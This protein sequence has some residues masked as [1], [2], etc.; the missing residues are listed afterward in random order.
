MELQSQ[1]V[2]LIVT[3]LLLLFFSFIY[4]SI[5]LQ[6]GFLGLLPT[7]YLRHKYTTFVNTKF[8]HA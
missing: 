4:Q 2:I 5:F 6:C 8:K 7:F 3:L 1:I